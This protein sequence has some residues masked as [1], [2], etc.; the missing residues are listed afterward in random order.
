MLAS[1]PLKAS[2]EGK[3]LC[4][5]FGAHVSASR[6]VILE[7][8]KLERMLKVEKT[9][10]GNLAVYNSQYKNEKIFIKVPIRNQAIQ[11]EAAMEL[12]SLNIGP[13]VI[14][15][16]K[17]PQGI[18]IAYEFITGPVI[19]GITSKY[20]D[21]GRLKQ[22]T[23]EH[24]EEYRKILKEVGYIITRDL[25]IMVRENGTPVVIDPEFF[26]RT[27]PEKWLGDPEAYKAE[28][29]RVDFQFDRIIDRVKDLIFLD[30][31]PIE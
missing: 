29:N 23:I 27:Y 14:G 4:K 9:G 12:Y 17:T 1:V 16:A 18:G 15:L 5:I 25:Q 7:G 10:L 13:K 22:S 31:I 11:L 3:H 28:R 2:E 19:N 21:S 24:L 8:L 20:P 26:S 6:I 30:S